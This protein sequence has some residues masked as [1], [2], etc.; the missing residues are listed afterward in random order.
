MGIGQVFD[1]KGRIF[2]SL[3]YKMTF[4]PSF[5]LFHFPQKR[6]GG[7]RERLD[8]AR[9]AS[10]FIPPQ[11]NLS[12]SAAVLHAKRPLLQE[13]E[14]QLLHAQVLLP[15]HFGSWRVR[16]R[17]KGHSDFNCLMSRAVIMALWED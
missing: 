9:S 1:S 15:D 2:F 8:A 17:G 3:G 14:Q 7:E 13:L 5:L 12:C 6:E 10:L 4:S 11:H 16:E